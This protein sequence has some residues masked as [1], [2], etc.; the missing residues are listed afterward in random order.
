MGYVYV[1]LN[2]I[3]FALIW[4]QGTKLDRVAVVLLGLSIAVGAFAWRWE[5]DG[6]RIGSALVNATMFVSIMALAER[7]DRWWMVFFCTVQ[8]LIMATHLVPF[9][10]P[11]RSFQM[12]GYVMRQALWALNT[13]LF[14]VAAWECWAARRFDR[15]HRHDLQLQ[16][17]R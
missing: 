9:I 2:L 11:E 14:F 16:G 12:T 6:W 7:H 1:L 3:A 5:I 8:L 4:R 17:S 10:L 13:L 15:E